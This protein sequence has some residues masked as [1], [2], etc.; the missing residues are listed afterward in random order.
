MS[1]LLSAFLIQD[2][3][4]ST[5]YRV[6]CWVGRPAK[7]HDVGWVF[8][9]PYYRYILLVQSKPTIVL[10][11]YHLIL[12]DSFLIWEK[13]KACFDRWSA[14]VLQRHWSVVFLLE[15]YGQWK[16]NCPFLLLYEKYWLF[17]CPIYRRRNSES[18][19]CPWIWTCLI[20]W[21]RC[22]SKRVSPKQIRDFFSFQLMRLL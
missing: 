14:W 7:H 3:T 15:F 1:S 16:K 11:V 18:T 4:T 20:Y 8:R 12:A 9:R 21:D 19:L 17:L 2:S 22:Q 13:N 10:W 5:A 6:P